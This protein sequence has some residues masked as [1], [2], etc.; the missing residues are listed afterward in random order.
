MI[1]EKLSV[2]VASRDRQFGPVGKPGH[3]VLVE[4]DPARSG[5]D[6][7]AAEPVRLEVGGVGVGV[8]LPFEGS[9][10]HPSTDP[11]ADVVAS[12]AG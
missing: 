10:D 4:A 6:R 2:V 11:G 7:H 1:V 3:G 9:S 8:P 5:V 12:L